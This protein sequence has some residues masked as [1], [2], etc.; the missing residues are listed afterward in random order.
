MKVYLAGPVFNSP[1]WGRTWREEVKDRDFPDVEWLDPTEEIPAEEA[2]EMEPE[3]LVAN[4]KAMIE[5]T[6]AILVGYERVEAIGTWREVEFG[7][8][9]RN[10]PVATWTGPTEDLDDEFS[11]WMFEAGKVHHDL[12]S[13]I[14]YLRREHEN[15]GIVRSPRIDKRTAFLTFDAFERMMTQAVQM[16]QYEVAAEAC[17]SLFLYQSQLPQLFEEYFE[18]VDGTEGTETVAAA[19]GEVRAWAERNGHPVTEWFEDAEE[20]IY[21]K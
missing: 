12:D 18:Q 4:D 17:S 9:S 14:G 16:Q 10:L 7:V 20:A 1:D 13:C 19:M 2:L 6:D 5:S 3:E 8:S 15:R 11:P 21:D